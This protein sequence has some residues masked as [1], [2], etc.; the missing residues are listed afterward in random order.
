M[1][2]AHRHVA[3]SAGAR[4]PAPPAND[5]CLEIREDWPSASHADPLVRQLARPPPDAAPLGDAYRRLRLVGLA[6]VGTVGPASKARTA[7][8]ARTSANGMGTA[9]SRSA[10]S[11]RCVQGPVF[12]CADSIAR[13]R[14]L[15]PLAP[16]KCRFRAARMAWHATC[17]R[18]GGQRRLMNEHQSRPRSARRW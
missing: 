17:S 10:A 14:T 1:S 2:R 12:A 7:R 11:A 8:A 9:H 5:A 15:Q 16:V 13:K 6:H 18:S 4:R 3:P